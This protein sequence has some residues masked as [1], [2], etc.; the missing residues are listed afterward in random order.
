MLVL[1]ERKDFRNTKGTV[2]LLQQVL[3]SNLEDTFCEIEKLLKILV[4]TPIK[5]VHKGGLWG[6]NP[7]FN[8]FFFFLYIME[9]LKID[10]CRF[11]YIGLYLYKD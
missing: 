2:A 5:G 6:L 7:S 1:Y 8:H 3:S 11:K 10:I 9:K 4:T